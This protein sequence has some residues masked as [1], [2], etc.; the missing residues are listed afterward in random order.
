MSVCSK[1][2]KLLEPSSE[3]ASAQLP[4]RAQLL[5]AHCLILLNNID[6]A[7]NYEAIGTASIPGSLS[8]MLC[9]T[10]EQLIVI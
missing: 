2:V 4:D 5:L 8:H 6:G 10:D 1:N 7:C 3:A 9:V